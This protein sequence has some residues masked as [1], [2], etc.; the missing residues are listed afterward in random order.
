LFD[1]LTVG[2]SLWVV[3]SAGLSRPGQWG[4]LQRIV[5]KDLKFLKKY[6]TPNGRPY[7]I[8][9]DPRKSLKL[10]LESQADF[11]AILRKLSFESGR[12]IRR[13]RGE[14]GNSLQQFRPLTASDVL[15][16]EKYIGLRSPARAGPSDEE[17]E[18]QKALR[19]LGAGFGDPET[20]KKVE[21]RAI[22]FA[23]K[24]Y[25]SRRWRVRSVERDKCGY[26]LVCTRGSSEEHV[27]VKGV[28]GEVRS[29]IITSGEI[30]RAEN[31]KSLTVFVLTGALSRRPIHR[32]YSGAQFLKRF[33]LSPL[34][35]KATLLE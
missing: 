5:V 14:I 9:G 13:S 35:Y 34:A 26:D 16:L 4:L 23:K 11:A 3:V 18:I 19:T 1:W 30:R 32:R 21:R 31:D 22:A 24:W 8:V 17:S 25:K 20:N 28:Q 27:E 15:L 33:S 2:D 6:D 7:R 29:F 12:R 10:S